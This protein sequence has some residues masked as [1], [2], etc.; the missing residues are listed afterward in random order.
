MVRATAIAPEPIAGFRAV[1][2]HGS[3]LWAESGASSAD[4][5]NLLSPCSSATH[6]CRHDRLRVSVAT[7]GNDRSLV[8]SRGRQQNVQNRTGRQDREPI[9]AARFENGDTIAAVGLCK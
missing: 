4:S 9:I 8:G 5:Q 7:L 3:E 6:P 2:L 1:D